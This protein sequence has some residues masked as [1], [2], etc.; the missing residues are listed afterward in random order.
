MDWPL[1]IVITDSCLSRYGAIFSFLL[2]LKL[3]MWTLKDICFHLKRTGE[4][5]WACPSGLSPGLRWPGAHP[6]PSR[7]PGEPHGALGAVPPA[8]AVQA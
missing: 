1:N 5:A 7:S 8:A 6:L 2:Q 3:M 4:A